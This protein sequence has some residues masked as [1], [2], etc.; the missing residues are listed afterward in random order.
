VSFVPFAVVDCAILRCL[1]FVFHVGAVLSGTNIWRAKLPSCPLILLVK[2]C[3]AR[4]TV[5]RG[6]SPA[7]G[8]WYLA[9]GLRACS[10]ALL[11]TAWR[12]D[13]GGRSV[14]RAASRVS[15]CA[16]AAAAKKRKRDLLASDVTSMLASSVTRFGYRMARVGGIL[17]AAG[18]YTT[19]LAFSSWQPSSLAG[20]SLLLTAQLPARC[21]LFSAAVLPSHLRQRRLR[22]GLA[23]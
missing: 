19:N 3:N 9:G 17:P 21:R 11:A 4:H 12:S 16:C 18:A 6:T 22:R 5:H 20:A 14:F 1:R 2:P 8:V 10:R 15:V 23:N 13:C 7:A